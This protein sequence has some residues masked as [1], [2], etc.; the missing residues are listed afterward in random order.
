MTALRLL[1]S[2]AGFSLFTL[3]MVMW[4][5]ILAVISGE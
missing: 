4:A 1:A 3:G 5:V 2:I